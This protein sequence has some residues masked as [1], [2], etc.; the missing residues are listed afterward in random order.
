MTNRNAGK[1]KVVILG[2][3]VGGVTAAF[4]LTQP[5]LAGQYDVTLYQ[6]G[7]RLGG[8]GASGRN[9]DAN[10][11]IEEH[12]LHIW[13]GFYYNAFLNMKRCYDELGRDPHAPLGSFAT[14]FRPQSMGTLM[15]RDGEAWSRWDISMPGTTDPLT[16]GAHPSALGY[17][18]M[19]LQWLARALT[20]GLWEEARRE[21]LFKALWHS[22]EFLIEG[23]E[24]IIHDALYAVRDARED[25]LPHAEAHRRTV[26]AARTLSTALHHSFDEGSAAPLHSRRLAHVF[27]IACATLVGLFEEGV[28][29]R[30]VPFAALDGRELRQFLSDYGCHPDSLDSPLL[31]GYYDL[32]FGFTRGGTGERFEDAAA[33]TALYA[34]LRVCFEYRG[35]FMWRME[36]GMGDTIFAPYYEVL[37]R[38]GVTFKFF[39]RVESLEVE[40]DGQGG[41][42]ISRVRM[43]RQVDVLGG[44]A[45]YAPLVDVKGLPCWPSVPDYRQLVQG[46]ALRHGPNDA[47]FNLESRWSGWT[48]VGDVVLQAGDFDHLVLAIPVGFHP[49]ICADLMTASPR[50]KSMV[51]KVQTVQ[52]FGV[53]LWLDRDITDMGWAVP[54]IGG[55]PQRAVC[56]AYADPLNSFADNSHLIAMEQ[57]TAPLVPKTLLYFCGVLSDEYP[58][59]RYAPSGDTAFPARQ[60]ARVRQQSID[61]LNA[62]TGQILPGACTKVPGLDWERLVDPRGRSGVARFDAQFWRAN[63]DP[64]ERYVL[65]VSG[66]TQYRLKAGDSQFSN[67]VLAGDWVDT[68]FSV[69]CVEAATMGGLQAA[70]AII[71]DAA[72]VFGEHTMESAAALATMAAAAPAPTSASTAA[73]AGTG[74]GTGTGT[75]RARGRDLPKFRPGPSNLELVPPYKFNKLEIRSFPLLADPA[76]L[77]KLVDQLNIA[78][79]EVCEFRAVGNVAFMQL[80]VY[81]YLESEPDPSGWFTENELSF[82]LLVACGKRVDG[83]FVPNAL[84]YYFPFIYVDNDWAIA[85][86]REVFGYPKIASEMHFGAAGETEIFSLQTLALPVQGADEQARIVKLVEIVETEQLDGWRKIVAEVEG[87]VSEFSDLIFGPNGIV[88]DASLG[89]L[90]SFASTFGK[91]QIGIVSLKQFRD[92]ADP[93]RACYQALVSTQFKIDTWHQ[94]APIPGKFAARI[95]R[96]ASMPII[97]SLG[98]TVGADG[99]VATLQPFVMQYDCTVTVGTNLYVA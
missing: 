2:G 26:T 78:P 90:E 59:G 18:E 61:W 3:G 51:D 93:S 33:G 76:K 53:Q 30:G 19:L 92:A 63:V 17:A 43:K 32:A 62:Y 28:V 57:W 4:A 96:E 9:P 71:G 95:L 40:P 75:G 37:K 68:G 52:T 46:Q 79:P 82:N 65:S 89:L 6:M 22:A 66:S 87:V 24:T 91:Q 16:G 69:G 72:P 80:A 23:G 7:W 11:R 25:G 55:Q 77:Q 1:K 49:I 60:D 94:C 34:I 83:V 44:D 35:A 5:E 50:F 12:G 85:T 10:Q 74:T 15:D 88:A 20:S 14:A 99:L 47:P 54:L 42:R 81:P 97:E 67:L 58:D 86:G 36:A 29:T 27:D 8:K 41:K 31:R 38:R 84:A 98:L 13:M 39:H 64:N 21:G 48:D 45:A 56:D 70:R 73:A